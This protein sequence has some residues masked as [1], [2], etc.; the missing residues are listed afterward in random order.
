M[1]GIFLP[2]LYYLNS[3]L[4]IAIEFRIYYL[5]Y[6]VQIFF[7]I[8]RNIVYSSYHLHTI[9]LLKPANKSQVLFASF[10]KLF[11]QSI[12]VYD[13]KAGTVLQPVRTRGFYVL[14]INSHYSCIINPQKFIQP[15]N[16]CMFLAFAFSFLF[17]NIVV[18]SII[19]WSW[20]TLKD[21][22]HLISDLPER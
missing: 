3:R 15:C 8:Y 17:Q 9:F 5:L 2:N 14:L 6:I 11:S 16:L 20:M 10:F 18:H 13:K 21:S 19:F 7:H 22:H 1:Q 12:F 4:N